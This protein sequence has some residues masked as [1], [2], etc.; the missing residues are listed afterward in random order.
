MRICLYTNTALPCVGGQEHVVDEL[1]R[2]IQ[3][4]GHEVAVLCPVAPR[5]ILARDGRLPY[6]VVRHRRFVSTRWFVDWYVS[7]LERLRQQFP[8]D[9]LHCHNVYPSGYLAALAAGAGRAPVVITSHG[10]D[11]R[12]G[13]PAVP[14]D[15][16]AGP[17]RS[18]SRG[19]GSAHRHQSLHRTGLPGTGGDAAATVP[20]SQWCECRTVPTPG[21]T[22]RGAAAPASPTQLCALSRPFGALKGVDVLLRARRHLDEGAPHL[23]IAG[24]GPERLALERLRSGLGLDA[25]VS[26][27]G[28]VQGDAKTWLL[29][30]A[31]ALAIP[32][33]EREAFPL[34]LLEGYA[35]GCAVVV[36][37]AAGLCDLVEPNVMG[38]VVP[39][40]DPAAWRTCS[41][42]CGQCRKRRRRCGGMCV[43][44]PRRT[45]GGMLPTSIW[46]CLTRCWRAGANCGGRPSRLCSP[47]FRGLR[48]ITRSGMATWAVATQMDMRASVPPAFMLAGVP[49]LPGPC[50]TRN[51]LQHEQSLGVP[52]SLPP[53]RH[54]SKG[55]PF[56]DLPN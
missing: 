30:N 48:L 7:T 42:S 15:G 37:D 41:S 40:N 23:V 50:E 16:F 47:I 10:G 45:T 21:G 13:Q 8:Y 49:V 43:K 29:Q 12:G 6:P 9:I 17:A 2:R 51:R 1:A 52:S 39:R 14:Q 34:V 19:S 38:W 27:V 18:G 22:A 33:R 55:D 54:F 36:S 24:E 56:V 28:H 44:W 11:V 46:Q 32:S 3:A 53:L 20:D 5:G 31:F 26:F 4:A 25:Q 35:A